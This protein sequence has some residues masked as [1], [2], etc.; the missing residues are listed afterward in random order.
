MK[1]KYKKVI[2][3]TTMST[4]GIG[5]LTLSL[6]HDK[7]NAQENNSNQIVQSVMSEE[8]VVDN[9]N[10]SAA[11]TFAAV[12]SETPTVTPTLSPEPT[13]LPVY[14]IEENGYPKITKLVENYYAA[15]NNRDV[16]TLKSLLSDPAKADTQ[17]ELKQKTEYIDDYR[18]I[19][20]YVK[21]GHTDGTYIVY[22]YHEIKFTSIKTPAPGLAKFYVVTDA[23]GELKI[24]S[25]KMDP[26]TQAYYDARN[27]DKDVAS[28]ISMT[29]KKSD[30]AIKSDKDLQ[31]FWKN[32]DQLANNS[33]DAN[34]STDKTAT[35]KAAEST[36][37]G[38][39]N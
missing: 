23:K 16:K 35:D 18:D 36:S 14:N 8:T 28:L 24:F 20:V 17:E 29:D 39:G 38:S 11:T 33:N 34:A 6:N 15:K 26:D 5:L 27:T 30:D 21:K 13:P 4:M 2:L 25:G 12:V 10:D 9:E 22:A 1:L 32:I 31:N 19:K 37:S 7:T 3:L